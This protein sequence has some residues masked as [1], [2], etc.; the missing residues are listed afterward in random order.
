MATTTTK[1]IRVEDSEGNLVRIDE[2]VMVRDTVTSGTFQE[3]SDRLQSAGQRLLNE[4]A[5]INAKITELS[6]ER[7]ELLALKEIAIAAFNGTEG[8]YDTEVEQ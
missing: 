6:N 2:T 1:I 5:Q 8:E 4:R 7:D 3:E